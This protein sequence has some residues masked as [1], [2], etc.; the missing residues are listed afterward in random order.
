[1]KRQD[2]ERPCPKWL[3]GLIIINVVC[4]FCYPIQVQPQ[5][6]EYMEYSTWVGQ[7]YHS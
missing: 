1:M 6:T 5:T 4:K 7:L 3:R 2:K